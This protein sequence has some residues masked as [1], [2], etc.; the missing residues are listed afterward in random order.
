[1][2]IVKTQEINNLFDIYRPLL[3]SKQQEIMEMYFLYD[4]SL[5][6]IADECQTTRAAAFDLIKR[7]SKLLENYEQKMHLLEKKIQLLKVIEKTDEKTKEDIL[8]II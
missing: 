1:M 2:D 5:S 8:K 6:E 7:T 3:T 4:L